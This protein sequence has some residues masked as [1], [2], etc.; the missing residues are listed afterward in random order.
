MWNLHRDTSTDKRDAPNPGGMKAGTLGSV[1][2]DRSTALWRAQHAQ[3]TSGGQNIDEKR[4]RGTSVSQPSASA[5]LSVSVGALQRKQGT[6]SGAT[7]LIRSRIVTFAL[8]A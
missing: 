3:G 4:V 2:G 5:L 1:H 7:G 6:Q 8:S